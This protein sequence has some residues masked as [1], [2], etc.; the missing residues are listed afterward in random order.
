MRSSPLP[1]VRY[2]RPFPRVRGANWAIWCGSTAAAQDCEGTF[3]SCAFWMVEA[4]GLPGETEE[5]NRLFRA[6]LAHVQNDV[7]L[8]PEMWDHQAHLG[9]GN[10]PQG[11]SNLALVHAA[12]AVDGE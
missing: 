10:T 9:L 1:R 3:I 11:L 5:A 2:L 4:Y 12:Y 7:G 6:L 8:M